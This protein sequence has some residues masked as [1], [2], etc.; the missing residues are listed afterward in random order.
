M[1]IFNSFENF[2][3]I[4]FSLI[5]PFVI[6]VLSSCRPTTKDVA[7]HQAFAYKNL[8]NVQTPLALRMVLP[9]TIPKISN[10]CAGDSSNNGYVASVYQG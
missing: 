5:D 7:F 1:T 8:I 9:S 2:S 6:Y 3:E 4:A 10:S